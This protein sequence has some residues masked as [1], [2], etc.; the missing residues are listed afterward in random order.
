MTISQDATVQTGTIYFHFVVLGPP[1]PPYSSTVIFEAL[2][3]GGGL[4]IWIEPWGQIRATVIGDDGKLL[5]D[6]ITCV[7]EFQ[8]TDFIYGMS[9]TL[10]GTWSA[11][12]N[13]NH[14][15]SS[16]PDAVIPPAVLLEVRPRTGQAHD[17]SHENTYATMQRRSRFAGWNPP[18][19]RVK[20]KPGYA[21][22][23]LR[24]EIRQIEDLLGL[25]A[26]GE[27]HHVPGLA[28]RI[29]MLIATGRPLPLLQLE[30]ARLNRPLTVYTSANPREPIPE[31]PAFAILSPAF[32]KPQATE[33]NPV[34]LDVWLDLPFGQ[35]NKRVITNR[36]ALKDIGD[37]I[38]S[39]FD[40]DI[41][42]SVAA[43]R[44]IGTT[45]SADA[46]TEYLVRVG[47]MALALAKS[48]TE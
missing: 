47:R 14:V 22:D 45:G 19:G 36:D 48:V 8:G 10:P 1:W 20:P 3:V 46:M 12:I 30:A 40:P 9:W 35:I 13:G 11:F 29:R 43:L 7:L 32:A 42:P 15:A 28:A 17:F 21:G 37:T 26:N 5:I 4:R 44:S 2:L 34:D 16:D 18:P 33:T 6:C 24:T 27:K 23:A 31:P 38:G 25:I 39:H 41:E